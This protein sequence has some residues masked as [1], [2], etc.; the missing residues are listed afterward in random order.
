M[1][2]EVQQITGVTMKTV[3]SG[4]DSGIYQKT[5]WSVLG[6]ESTVTT[7][8]MNTN[9]LR[10]RRLFQFTLQ[11]I[12]FI[13]EG[14]NNGE[15]FRSE[16]LV[17]FFLKNG[18]NHNRTPGMEVCYFSINLNVTGKKKNK[19]QTA[20]KKWNKIETKTVQLM[21]FSLDLIWRT[22]V[23]MLLCWRYFQ[24]RFFWGLCLM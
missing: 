11:S 24:F 12:T 14:I 17:N 22:C 8:Q 20:L 16:H 6:T 3:S 23:S 18:R 10:R 19:K 21:G 2:N 13:T 4:E 15:K 7:Q 1:V 5:Y 9:N